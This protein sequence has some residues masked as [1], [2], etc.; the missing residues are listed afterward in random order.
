[1]IRTIFTPDSKQITFPIPEKYIGT[2]LEIIIFHL[3]DVSPASAR[4]QKTPVF[5]CAKGKFKMAD[6]FDAP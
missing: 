6:D 1:M 4:S 5:G 2:E 3:K